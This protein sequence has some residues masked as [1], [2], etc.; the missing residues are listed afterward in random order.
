M[1][2]PSDPFMLLSYLNT[3]LRD[4]FD[5]LEELCASICLDREAVCQ[6]LQDAGFSYDE[7]RNQFR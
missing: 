3:Q 2:V 1:S 4:G 5:S 6:K 7:A